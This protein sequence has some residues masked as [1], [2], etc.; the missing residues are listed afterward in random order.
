MTSDEITILQVQEHLDKLRQMLAYLHCGRIST[1]G[2]SRQ[3]IGCE[4]L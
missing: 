2:V 4:R 3:T 1:I